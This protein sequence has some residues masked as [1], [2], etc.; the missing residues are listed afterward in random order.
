MIA[1]TFFMV[2]LVRMFLFA[3]MMNMKQ[4]HQKKHDQNPYEHGACD[5][6]DV[7][8]HFIG[9]WQEVQK[10]HSQHQTRDQTHHDLHADVGQLDNRWKPATEKRSTCDEQAINAQDNYRRHVAEFTN[11]GETKT[12]YSSS[13]HAFV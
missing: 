3:V 4:T 8:Q 5:H 11:K 1:I 7:I 10:C 12:Q 13:N 9:M 2:V 6:V